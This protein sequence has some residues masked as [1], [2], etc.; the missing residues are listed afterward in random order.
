MRNSFAFQGK[1]SMRVDYNPPKEAGEKQ[2]GGA[3]DRQQ[4][5]MGEEGGEEGG[6]EFEGDPAA[7]GEAGGGDEA[8][9]PAGVA[10]KR[11]YAQAFDLIE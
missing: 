10:K 11:R 6:E 2:T 4:S 3:D 7:E 8:G 5:E 9:G 1:I